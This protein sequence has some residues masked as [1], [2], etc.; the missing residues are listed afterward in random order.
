[1]TRLDIEQL[2]VQTALLVFCVCVVVWLGGEI[3]R[4]WRTQRRF[5][6]AERRYDAAERRLRY[7]TIRSPDWHAA[8]IDMA[9][10]LNDMA[11]IDGLP[12]L[13]PEA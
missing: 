5:R 1:M 13:F 2:A 9:R 12:R 8:R 10:A 3:W 11:E 4:G 6:N 7:A